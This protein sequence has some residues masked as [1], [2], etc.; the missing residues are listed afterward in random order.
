MSSSKAADFQSSK[1]LQRS[2]EDFNIVS[3]DPLKSTENLKVKVYQY[4][5]YW[6]FIDF[7]NQQLVVPKPWYIL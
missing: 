2:S 6:N 3:N 4:E 5:C 7:L 1:N